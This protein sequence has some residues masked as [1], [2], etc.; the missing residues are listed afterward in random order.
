MK[1]L[2]CLC[3]SCGGTGG[4]FYPGLSIART[5]NS[6][7]GKA[8]LLLG[9]IHAENQTKIA[10]SFG[11][12]AFPVKA[13][14]LSK[15]PLKLLSF[16]WSTLRGHRQCRK[17]YKREKPQALLCMGSFASLPPALAAR[18]NGIP[19]F[20]H[21]GNARVGKANRMLS[22]FARALALSFPAVNADSVRCPVHITGLPLRPELL[23]DILTK[24]EAIRQINARWNCGF[25]A[26]K[27]VAFVFGGSLGAKAIN[28]NFIP[29]LNVPGMENLQLIHLSGPGKLA[30][31]KERY[32]TLKINALVLESASELHWFYA[33]SDLVFCRAGG[34]TVSEAAH[35]GKYT[36]L[37][38]YPFAAEGHQD[39]NARWLSAGEGAEI[40][41]NSECLPE[42]F[43]ALLKVFLASPSDFSERG[44]KS[45]RLASPNA[46]LNVL[47][48]IDQHVTVM[49]I[50]NN[51]L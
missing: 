41:S 14:Q 45:K 40:L 51:D 37:I 22:R 3:I 36:V 7:G 13:V 25:D 6:M 12:E 23:T 18:F 43:N 47:R 26:D 48:V 28:D 27:P 42:R 21:D 24:E 39:D 29:D 11:V 30:E 35:F 20:L 46:S 5:F 1:N 2:K 17:L 31:L 19:L 38:P 50:M 10:A 15:N 9:G 33:A 16:L 49:R 4:H 8:I 34:S 32:A 44:K